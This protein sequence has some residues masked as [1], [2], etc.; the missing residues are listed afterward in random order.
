MK[1]FLR[2]M[3]S[4]IQ[5]GMPYLMQDVLEEMD[6]SLEPVL[7][8]AIITD[9]TRKILKL[10]DKELD[11]SEDFK[12]FMT[13]KL[14]NPHYTPE[15][16]TKVT[17]VNFA[18]KQEGLEA[19]LLGIVVQEEEPSLEEQNTALV[20]K[21]AANK[22]KLVEL[23][24]TILELLSNSSGSLL[25]DEEL[26]NTLNSSKVTF[27]EV[28]ESLN[29]AEATKQKIDIAR[30]G[31]RGVSVRAAMLYFVLY[32]LS[33]VDPMYQFS[34]AT[35]ID[36][37]ILSIR[38]A[39]GSSQDER[40]ERIASV[41]DYH[42]FAIYKYAC[43]GLF[44]RHKPLL[45]FQICIKKMQLEGKIPKDEYDFFLRGG[46]VLD[47]SEQRPNPNA[48]WLNVAAWDNVTELEKLASFSGFGNALEQYSRD[49][50]LWFMSDAPESKPLPGEWDNK[51]NEMQKMVI[52]RSL[53]PD[54]ALFATSTFIAHNLG[55]QFVD[56]PPFVLKDIVDTSNAKTPL[57][58]ILSPG[59]DP[60]HQ[61][62][63]LAK[64]EGVALESCSLGQ[65]QAPIATKMIETGLA[66]GNWVFL[67]NCHLSIS[68]MPALEKI[69]E[70]FCAMTSKPNPAFRL[71][72]SSKPN[73][74]FPI[75]ILQAAIKMTTEPPRGLRPNLLRLYNQLTESHFNRVQQ[76]G[77]YRKM[78][79]ALCYFHAVLL[80]RRKFKALGWNIP[81]EFNDSDW[82]ICE[83]ILGIYLD[84]DPENTPF[85]AL[86]YLVAQANY[87]GRVT[88][89]WDRR[90]VLVYINQFFCEE[91]LSV[92]NF[93][94]S[95]LDKY[96]I[97]DDG[98][99]GSYKDY[100]NKLPPNDPP[101]AFGQHPNADIA[102]QI[103]ET[104]DF[105][106][107]ILGLQPK[108][109]V[110]GGE[111]N[112]EKVLRIAKDLSSKEIPTFDLVEIKLALGARSDPDPLKV[113]LL[114][115]IERYN[116]LFSL[117]TKSLSDLQKGIQGF[118]VI[119]QELEAV[120]DALLLGLVPTSWSFC[121]PSLK[122][123]GA[124]MRDLLERHH[125]M[126]A[127]AAE[128]MPKVFWMSGF[129]YP[130]G[131]LTALLQTSARKNGNSID[132]L[133]W[134]FPILKQDPAS[135]T[136]YPKEGAYV[137]GIFLEGARWNVEQNCLDDANPMELVCKM[138]MV[139]FKP[140]DSKKKSSK[141]CCPPGNE[142]NL[143][144]QTKLTHCSSCI[145]AHAIS[146]PFGRERENAH[147]LSS[148]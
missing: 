128:A 107:T 24:D 69:I 6:P 78:L 22:K 35:Y 108:T 10:G 51:L 89:D 15:I 141:V 102:S 27:E 30:Q 59:V 87:G 122:P 113:V 121:Y 106:G 81:Y 140:V 123:L 37:F 80:E 117:I 79:F 65:G 33:R 138:P 83:D 115:E 74:K 52:I 44:E 34:L 111:T 40:A 93:P 63:A 26:V 28:Q 23:E 91:T 104:N 109:V 118:V 114:Q 134:E 4:A 120:Y 21:V 96:F 62:R 38:N 42:T 146:T 55:A 31:Y 32:D 56:P 58:F 39:D 75:S 147:L 82:L 54:R 88:D 66:E 50:K 105:L 127:W 90:L 70:H 47:R 84:E 143:T 86:R 36:L 148:R 25:D 9:G 12:F 97:P 67:A 126:K 13:T 77:K 43:R 92:P 144:W 137:S 2:K 5:Y 139:H 100:I 124:W 20:L 1:D 19:Q 110:E 60:V 132:V 76:K 3:E 133:T 98:E 103:Q 49:W 135:V 41:N 94:L 99:L 17:I 145:L 85:E 95:E 53:R 116:A 130:S 14:S 57:V 142:V 16:S 73:D 68:W 72:L 11:Y 125:Q 112:D 64:S 46:T 7:A 101:A 45:S 71:W 129:T 119:T 8:K 136:Q 61:V 48:S 131:F 29:I 18:V